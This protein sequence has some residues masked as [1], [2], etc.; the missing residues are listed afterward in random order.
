MRRRSTA[1]SIAARGSAAPDRELGRRRTPRRRVV[2]PERRASRGTG[3]ASTCFRWASVTKLVT[4]LATLVAVEEGVVDLDEPAGPEG[5]RSGICSPTPAGCR[6]TAGRRSRGRARGGSTR[7]R[8]SRRSPSTSRHAR[9]CRSPSISPRRCSGRSGWRPSCAARPA[10]TFT[11]RSAT[12]S[13]S[14]AS[15]SRRRSSRRRRSRRRR[16]SH[17][18]G[19]RRRPARLRPLG[20][21]RLGP[22]LRAQGREAPA[23]GPGRSTRRARSATSAAAGTFL[24]VDPERALALGVL[25][26]LEFGEWAKTAWPTLSDAVLS[27]G[28]PA[29]AG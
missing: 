22:R 20:P 8:A 16:P 19:P 17:F 14:R 28:S 29:G 24:W 6:S 18:P 27:E 11:A 12:C 9:R 21:E 3:P 1:S 23:T 7:T 4:A 15:C 26:D 5:R 2:R 10:R 13:R 25:T